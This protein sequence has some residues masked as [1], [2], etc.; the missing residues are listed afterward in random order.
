MHTIMVMGG[1]FILLG[2]MMLVARWLTKGQKPSAGTLTFL[3]VW[4]ACTLVN[5]WVG[6]TKA[7][8]PLAEE[9]V[10]ALVV[11]AVPAALA[12]GMRGLMRAEAR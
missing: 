4:L 6:V 5:L 11:F 2:A 12:L 8:Y 3:P 9:A 7:G 10:I 1:G